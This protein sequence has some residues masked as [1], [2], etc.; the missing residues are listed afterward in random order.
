MMNHN[1][2]NKNWNRRIVKKLVKN[3]KNLNQDE[4]EKKKS[5][6]TEK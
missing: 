1:R 3:K 4:E 5:E 6:Q 2:H